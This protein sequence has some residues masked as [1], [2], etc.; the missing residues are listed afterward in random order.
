[1]INNYLCIDKYRRYIELSESCKAPYI[2]NFLL[3]S[4]LNLRR[5]RENK[6]QNECIKYTDLIFSWNEY[7]INRYQT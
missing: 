2:Y 7:E 6:L 3:G 4:V 1:M 5:E